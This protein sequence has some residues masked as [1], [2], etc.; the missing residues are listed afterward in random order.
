MTKSQEALRLASETFRVFSV[1][2]KDPLLKKHCAAMADLCALSLPMKHRFT[3][4]ECDKM[5]A[6]DFITGVKL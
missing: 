1:R 5:R 6:G 4:E 2:L 3:R